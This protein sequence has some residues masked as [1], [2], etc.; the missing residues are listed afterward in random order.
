MITISYRRWADRLD[1]SILVSLSKPC[2]V[3]FVLYLYY[4]TTFIHFFAALAVGH[5]Y[6]ILVQLFEKLTKSRIYD[7]STF[8]FAKYI[9][10]ESHT[11]LKFYHWLF[12]S[13]AHASIDFF[14]PCTHLLFLSNAPIPNP[15]RPSFQSFLAHVLIRC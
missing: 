10:D 4:H 6:H 14:V 15:T 1:L 2:C 11:I 3:F 8:S 9:I 5:Y 12:F 13:P 7:R